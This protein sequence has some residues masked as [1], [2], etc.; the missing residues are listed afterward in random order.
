MDGIS[1]QLSNEIEKECLTKAAMDLARNKVS[2]QIPLTRRKIEDLQEL[3]RLQK[4]HIID[5]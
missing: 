3:A 5:L 4:D 1:K 2:K